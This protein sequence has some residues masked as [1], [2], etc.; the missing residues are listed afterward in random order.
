MSI[1]PYPHPHPP[2]PPFPPWVTIC[3]GTEWPKRLDLVGSNL[4]FLLTDFYLFYLVYSR[5]LRWGQ[6]AASLFIC[7]FI[8]IASSLY[9]LCDE[10]DPC[11]SY[12]VGPWNLLYSLDFIGSYLVLPV[13]A[14]WYPFTFEKGRYALWSWIYILISIIECTCYV[15]L[16]WTCDTDVQYLSFVILADQTGLFVLAFT[17]YAWIKEPENT[18]EHL[19]VKCSVIAG[20]IA[21]CC[22]GT[23]LYFKIVTNYRP[24]DEYWWNHPIWH[25]LAAL[26]V[27]FAH[28]MYDTTIFRHMWDKA[29][30]LCKRS[31]R[32]R[33]QP[34]P[35][36]LLPSIPTVFISSPLLTINN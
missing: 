29:R 35:L 36:P 25:E 31:S 1:D 5:G 9:H 10:S 32:P 12:C 7:T 28:T 17:I 13:T 33:S 27:F 21:A 2:H 20:G 18:E 8:T 4:V 19:K 15:R 3:D 26:S 23:A 30:A 6:V 14:A 24:A 22:I 34:D 16:C 11:A